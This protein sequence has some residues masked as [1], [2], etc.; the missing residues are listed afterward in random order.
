MSEKECSTCH[1]IKPLDEFYSGRNQ[2]KDC[3]K[4]LAVN[5]IKIMLK[6]VK[7]IQT[8]NIIKIML[9]V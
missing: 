5:I 9:K 3:I 8:V 1:N 6:S 7:R 4:E 2:C